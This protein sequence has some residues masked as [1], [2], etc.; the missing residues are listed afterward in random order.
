VQGSG[1]GGSYL[2]SDMRAAYYGGALTGNGQIVGLVQFDGYNI[3]DVTAAFNGTASATANGSNYVLGYTPPAGGATYTIPI[4]NV[5]LDGAT[6]SPGQFEPPA[7]DA[8]QVL[9][10]VQSVGMA[11]GLSQVRVYIGASDADILN[12]IASESENLAMQVSI[13]CTWYPDD[14]STDDVFSEEFALQGQSVFV[15]SGDY[16]AYSPSVPYY[17][18]AEDPWVTAVGGT[19]LTTNGAGGALT[20]ETAWG[21]SGGG[22]SP[23][24][25]PIPTWQ[26]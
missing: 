21:Q 15:A 11:P 26:E 10:I 9:D 24:G 23:D 3:S 6:G 5:L 16:G 7:D 18:P 12:A 4:N 22:I 25:I 13:S 1:P 14:P 20:S 19:S 17:Y 2:S 8:E